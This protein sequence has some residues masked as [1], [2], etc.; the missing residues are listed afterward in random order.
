MTVIAEAAQF[1]VHATEPVVIYQYR[2]GHSTQAVAADYRVAVALEPPIDGDAY[3]AVRQAAENS[4]QQ[5]EVPRGHGSSSIDIQYL[6]QQVL[7]PAIAGDEPAPDGADTDRQGNV[8]RLCFKRH[9]GEDVAGFLGRFGAALLEIANTPSEKRE[10]QYAPF[11]VGT[12]HG[13]VRH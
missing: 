6:G 5:P 13:S 10:L 2:E 9:T 11:T 1:R 12:V 8:V 7:D 4:W 3:A